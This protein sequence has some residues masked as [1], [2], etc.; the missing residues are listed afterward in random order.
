M[1]DFEEEEMVADM[2][3]NF[4]LPEVGKFNARQQIKKKQ[5]SYLQSAHAILYENSSDS[6]PVE[7]INSEDAEKI[8][9]ELLFQEDSDSEE[10]V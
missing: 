10:S 4:V 7:L 6:L 5:Q 3:Y 1:T 2:I 8:N 9:K